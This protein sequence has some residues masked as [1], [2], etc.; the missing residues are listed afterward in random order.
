MDDPV[1]MC[2]VFAAMIGA[3]GVLSVMLLIWAMVKGC[4]RNLY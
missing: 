3:A 2:Y 1:T 4:T